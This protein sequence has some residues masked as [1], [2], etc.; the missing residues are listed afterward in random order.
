MHVITE[1]PSSG[2]TKLGLTKEAIQTDVELKL[3]LAGMRIEST[4]PEFLYIDVN[5]A[6]DGSAVSID[7]ELVQPVGLTRNPSIFIPGAITWSAGTLGT[8]PTSAQFIRD[9]IKDQVDKFL[10]A[11]LSVNP[12]K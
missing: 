8:N 1:D 11:W 7:V 2:G 10:N 9:A 6:R 5:V 3:R 4:T 12:K